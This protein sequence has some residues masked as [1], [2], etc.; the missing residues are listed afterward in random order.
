ML[1]GL[2]GRRFR[3]SDSWLLLTLLVSPAADTN[4]PDAAVLVELDAPVRFE[5]GDEPEDLRKAA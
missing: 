3:T 4:D 2:L 5:F 1:V